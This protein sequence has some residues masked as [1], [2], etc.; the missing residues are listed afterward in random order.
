MSVDLYTQTHTFVNNSLVHVPDQFMW[1]W[2]HMCD[3]ANSSQTHCMSDKLQMETRIKSGVSGS[4]ST[5]DISDA[6][7]DNCHISSYFYL[8]LS[9]FL[10]PDC[11]R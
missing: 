4:G 5:T 10:S 3:N 2:E 8:I 7:R 6:N 1:F 11:C 9:V